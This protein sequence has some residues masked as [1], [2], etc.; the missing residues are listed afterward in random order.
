RA[1][2]VARPDDIVCMTAKVEKEYLRF[3]S[4]LGIGPKN[5]NLVVASKD[6]HKNS[7]V[8][9]LDLL[10][11][12]RRA[13]STIRSLV[14]QNKKIVLNPYRVS[15]RELKFTA[16]LKK[17]LGRKVCL[18]GGG[19]DVVDYANQKHNVRAKALELGV[20]VPDGKVIELN[21][22]GDGRLLDLTA[23]RTAIL[24]FI[25]KTG[26]VLIKGSIG[27]MGDSLFI[28]E[29]NAGSI[30]KALDKIAERTDNR[31]YI[32]EVMFDVIV[33]PNIHVFIE[34]GKGRIFCIGITD[35]LLRDDLVHEGNI[36]PPSANTLNEMISSSLKI[37]KWLQAVGY[38]GFAGFDFGEYFDTE[39]GEIKHFLAEINPRI[40]A[41]FY[42]KVLMEHLNRKQTQNGRPTIEAFLSIEKKTKAKSFSELCGLCGDLF[43]KPETGKGLV[44][45]NIGLL[46]HGTFNLAVFG[47]S[48][49][50][51]LEMYEDFKKIIK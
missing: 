47:K 51:V 10:M 29:N 20:P 49:D 32:I 6:I 45:Y 12:D 48:G 23:V 28:V 40:N 2:I 44:P 13:V 19:S 18:L 17:V 36:Y 24:K 21:V 5:C 39:T 33:S 27:V 25:N 37:S 26:R 31:M 34:P 4:K 22:N 46:E 30:Q 9:L 7:D 3:L 8:R 35:Q 16:V 11:R 42:P 38:S 43:F 1:L 15:E 50:E 14:K 41:A